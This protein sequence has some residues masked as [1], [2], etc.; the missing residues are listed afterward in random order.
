M[1]LQILAAVVG[2]FAFA[3]L[4]HAPR[5]SYLFCAL[6]GGFAWAMYLLFDRLG[7]SLFLASALAVF[8]LTVVSRTLSVA[9]QL[10]ATVFI[11]TG[12]FPIVPGAGIYYTAYGLMTGDML[13]FRESGTNTV[14]LAGAIAIG[15]V[16]GMSVPSSIPGTLGRALG[17]I[18]PRW[19]LH[20][21][22]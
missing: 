20:R 1:L 4:F 18:L 6:V 12:I 10:P 9:M 22:D 3:V 5:R 13:M 7:L 16:V 11:V 21:S 2:V 19:M 17:R 15:I 14:A 8:M